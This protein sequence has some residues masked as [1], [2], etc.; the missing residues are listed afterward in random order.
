LINKNIIRRNGNVANAASKFPLNNCNVPKL[1]RKIPNIMRNTASIFFMGKLYTK[2][3]L[4][5]SSEKDGNI[6]GICS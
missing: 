1:I 6:F 2:Y 4:K 3:D 5:S